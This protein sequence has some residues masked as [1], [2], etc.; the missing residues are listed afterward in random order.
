MSVI[1][2]ICL[3][4]LWTLTLKEGMKVNLIM[5][6]NFLEYFPSNQMNITFELIPNKLNKPLI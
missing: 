1:Q 2:K 6:P 5:I 3:M 4:V